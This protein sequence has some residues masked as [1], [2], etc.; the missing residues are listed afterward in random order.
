VAH[1][2]VDNGVPERD[3]RRMLGDNPGSLL[4]L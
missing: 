2:L 1:Q 3:V 4:N